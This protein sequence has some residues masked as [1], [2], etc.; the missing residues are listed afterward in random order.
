MEATKVSFSAKDVMTLRE[1]TGLGMMDCKEAL[2]V[3]NGDM[4]AAEEWLRAKL[5]GKMDTRTERT[6]AEGRLGIAVKGSDAVIVEVRSETDFTSRNDEFVK[7]VEDVANAA[8]KLPAGPIKPDDAI[9]KRVDDVRIKTGENVNFARGEK[10]QGG[11]FGSYLHHD[12]KKGALVQ[13]S[14]NVAPEVLKGICQHIVAIVPP[15]IGVDEN[16]VAP[17][18]IGAIREAAIAEAKQGGKN[19]QIAQKIGDGKVRK[20]LE[21]NTLIHQKYVAD[22]SKAVK[23]LLPKDVKVTKFVRYTVGG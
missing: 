12:G 1:K 10:L 17:E 20:Y 7:L 23:D 16:D 2:T 11:T 21:E 9:T 8:I 18:T 15:P 3:S 14:G 6:T 22:D 4:K 19:D 5:K 13:V